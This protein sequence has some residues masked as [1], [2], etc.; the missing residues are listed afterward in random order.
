ME[1]LDV[2]NSNDN[3]VSKLSDNDDDNCDHKEDEE[4][5]L[6]NKLV[7][8]AFINPLSLVKKR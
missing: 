4:V 3:V 6:V 7:D 8:D 5:V 2:D 1:V